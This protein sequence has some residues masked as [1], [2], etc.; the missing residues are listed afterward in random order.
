LLLAGE[1]GLTAGIE[2]DGV[3]ASEPGESHGGKGKW[4]YDQDTGATS[5]SRPPAGEVRHQTF[6]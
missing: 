2:I 6:W 4:V 5:K 1:G 3:V